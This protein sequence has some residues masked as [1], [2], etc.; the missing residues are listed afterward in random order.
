MRQFRRDYPNI[1]FTVTRDQ[2]ELLD[3]SIS[4][5]VNNILF[6]TLLACLIIFFFM[7]DL[8]SPTL[9]VLTIPVTLIVSLLVFY[10]LGISINIVS[11]SGLI[12]G[13]G[14]MVDNSIVVIDNITARWQRGEGLTRAVTRGTKEVVAPML[15]SVLT[16]CYLNKRNTE[17]G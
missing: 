8:K 9:V 7:C 10:L 17:T 13:I 11:L 3:Y 14:M 5:L 4:N 15:S 16:T 6:G 12:L 2:T 1:E